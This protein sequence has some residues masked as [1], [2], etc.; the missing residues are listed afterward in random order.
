MKKRIKFYVKPHV[1]KILRRDYNYTDVLI[2]KKRL[3]IYLDRNL[4]NFQRYIQP[5]QELKEI[6]IEGPDM[7]ARKAYA[8]IKRI[9]MQFRLTMNTYVLGK[10]E[11]G[12][13]ARTAVRDFIEKYDL[14]E[15]E[16]KL[17]SCYKD[18]QRFED[19]DGKRNLIPLWI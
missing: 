5:D 3:H 17:D 13:P 16:I 1:Y 2:I 4:D 15:H 11:A 9:E 10:V 14:E 6:L 18:W 8:I 19:T 7:N 12:Y